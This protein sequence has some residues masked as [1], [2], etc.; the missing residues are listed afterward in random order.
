MKKFFDEYRRKFGRLDQE[1]VDGLDFIV[2]RLRN[3]GK[4]SDEEIAYI[5]A[6]IKHETADTYQ[7]IAEY[8]G[9]ARAERLYYSR[10]HMRKQLGNLYPGDGA[11]YKGRGYV[12]ITGRRNYRVLGG[13]LGVDLESSPEYALDP[14]IALQ[15]LEL[16]M[17]EGLFTGKRL[18]HYLGPKKKDFKSARKIING[19]DKASLIAGHATKFLAIL[20]GL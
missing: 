4:Y 18:S 13:R 17:T 15:I 20:K 2:P 3:S 8:G 10:P 16:G 1:Q 7:P 5:L 9:D 19:M 12:Q 11:K 6:T 14:L